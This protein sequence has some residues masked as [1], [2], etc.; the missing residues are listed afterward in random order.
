M[1]VN[2]PFHFNGAGRTATTGDEDHIRDLVELFL[3]TAPGER[4]NRPDF[5]SGLLALVFEPNSPELAAVV[6]Q[7]I[8]AGLQHWLNDL[9]EVQTLEVTAQDSTLRVVVQYILRRTGERRTTT[10]ERSGMR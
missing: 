6:Q 10:L 7:T 9:L 4:V 2:F 1:N 8:R 3:F 5:G